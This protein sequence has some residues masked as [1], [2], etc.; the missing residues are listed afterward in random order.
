MSQIVL[1]VPPLKIRFPVRAE[2]LYTFDNKCKK[3]ASWCQ[4]LHTWFYTVTLK[5]STIGTRRKTLVYFYSSQNISTLLFL[6]FNKIYIY[7]SD[8][9]GQ[10]GF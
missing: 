1:V 2:K 5:H 10:W 4:T 3:T 9:K 7:T 6:Y 8:L